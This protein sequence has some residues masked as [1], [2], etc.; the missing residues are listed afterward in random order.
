MALR[1][2]PRYAPLLGL[3]TI[4]SA[5]GLPG[6]ALAANQAGSPSTAARLVDTIEPRTQLVSPPQ[7]HRTHLPSEDEVR[8]GVW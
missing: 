8:S 5:T 6:S 2:F 7:P 4:L 3:L 1:R